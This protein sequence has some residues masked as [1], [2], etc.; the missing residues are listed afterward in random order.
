MKISSLIVVVFISLS[1]FAQTRLIRSLPY[2]EVTGESQMT[3]VP[4]KIELSIR[5]TE[6]NKKRHP[7]SEIEHAL[8][9][10]L[11]SIG[12]NPDEQLVIED[13]D[14]NIHYGVFQPTLNTTKRYKLTLNDVEHVSKVYEK[15]GKLRV[16]YISLDKVDHS[17]LSDYK[18]KTK[19]DAIKSAKK[20]ADLMLTEIGQEVKGLLFVEEIGIEHEA[21]SYGYS[22]RLRS[23]GA[24]SRAL[25]SDY[26]EP[27]YNLNFRE[28]ILDY[29]ILARFEIE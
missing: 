19:V 7:I 14:G 2:V 17:D 22:Y 27:E 29:K 23:A 8:V 3:I 4:D 20:K 24:V 6:R 21:D 15:V 18:S 28:I 9:D 12:I 16:D 13:I 1:S 11:K 25:A 10:T 26:W 5:I